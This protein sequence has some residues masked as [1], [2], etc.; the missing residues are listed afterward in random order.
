VHLLGAQQGNAYARPLRVVSQEA[1]RSV[2]SN[3]LAAGGV[4]AAFRWAFQIPPGRV[5]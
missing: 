2:I 3:G 1:A 4:R 5:L